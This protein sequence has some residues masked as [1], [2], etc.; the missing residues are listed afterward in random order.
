VQQ[1]SQLAGVH[2]SRHFRIPTL[3]VDLFAHSH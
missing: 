3:I 2:H 1:Q